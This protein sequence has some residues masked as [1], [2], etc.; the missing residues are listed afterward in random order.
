VRISFD[1]E[2]DDIG[3][4]ESATSFIKNMID[5]KDCHITSANLYLSIKNKDGEP[6]YIGDEKGNKT[7]YIVRDKPYKNTN[8]L[9]TYV[10]LDSDGNEKL[11]IYEG[12]DKT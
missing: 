6:C 5:A 4:I 9:A 2:I 11:Y 10:I 8:K 3:D 12:V 1:Y 7:K